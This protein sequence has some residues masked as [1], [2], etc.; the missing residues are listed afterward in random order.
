MPAPRHP[1]RIPDC[2]AKYR[3][4]RV[5]RALFGVHNVWPSVSAAIDEE[6]LCGAGCAIVGSEE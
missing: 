6:G 1:N 5:H 2:V 3:I 4:G